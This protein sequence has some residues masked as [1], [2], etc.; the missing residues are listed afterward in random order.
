MR[1]AFRSE[2]Q[3]GA[4]TVVVLGVAAS[5]AFTLS[6]EGYV[7]ELVLNPEETLALGKVRPLSD[8]MLLLRSCSAKCMHTATARASHHTISA[9]CRLCQGAFGI[10]I[11]V[12]HM[13]LCWLLN[14]DNDL[15]NACRF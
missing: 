1:L 8:C 10:S 4:Y 15:R 3:Q 7:P 13:V 11:N 14:L 2:L 5:S 6:A 12:K 9:P